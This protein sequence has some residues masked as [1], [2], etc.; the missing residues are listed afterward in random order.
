ML[1][2]L[3]D[4]NEASIHIQEVIDGHKKSVHFCGTCA[5]K[6]KIKV[7]PSED[8][9]FAKFAYNCSFL[10]DE[11]QKQKKDRS[12]LSCP[13]CNH[14]SDD[15]QKTGRLGCSQCYTTFKEILIYVLPLM[16]K[17]LIHKGKT[18]K[19]L[20]SMPIELPARGP[21]KNSQIK[22]VN[23][24]EKNL[25]TAIENENFELAAILRDKLVKIK[26]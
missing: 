2:D 10:M 12:Q 17:D 13:E 19:K 23:E 9:G 21:S 1:C 4:Q 3:C 20:E 16:H 24:I 26:G 15:F 8:L 7:K 25:Q 14:T 11:R 18:I 22:K 5:T 6:K